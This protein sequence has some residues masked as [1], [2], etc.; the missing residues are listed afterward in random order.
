MKSSQTAFLNLPDQLF[1]IDVRPPLQP[2][3][4]CDISS[5][6]GAKEHCGLVTFFPDGY[7]LEALCAAITGASCCIYGAN[8]AT[9]RNRVV[10]CMFSV[11]S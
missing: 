8:V 2:S 4:F 7:L 11:K 10:L 3:A 5:A 1:I 6:L 9:R